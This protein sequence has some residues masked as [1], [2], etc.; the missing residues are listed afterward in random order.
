MPAKHQVNLLPKDTFEKSNLGRFV[1]WATSIGR[2]IIVFT[3]LVVICSFFSRFYFDTKLADLHDSIKQNQ[4]IIAANSDFE[5]SFRFLQK[6]FVLAKSLS[7]IKFV[8][9]EKISFISSILPPD[10]YLNNFV[11]DQETISFS[12]VSLSPSGIS[13]FLRSLLASPQVKNINITQL[14]V[15]EKNQAETISFSL[16]ITWKKI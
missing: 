6:K 9:E 4:A 13:N 2:W 8:G 16:S 11:F 7:G 15:E 10:V 14:G 5:E 3:D 1:K 12:G